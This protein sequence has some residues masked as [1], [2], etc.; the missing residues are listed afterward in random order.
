[1]RDEPEDGAKAQPLK[2]R[3]LERARR[4]QST[5]RLDVL[6]GMTF[7]NLVMFAIIVATAQTLHAHKKTTIPSA[8]QAAAGLLA[9][10]V[11]AGAGSVGMAGL[12]GKQWGSSRSARKALFSTASLRWAQSVARR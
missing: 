2:R 3:S 6:T 7:S 1:M 5:S 4:K 12:P 8:A 10:P 11:L 9:I